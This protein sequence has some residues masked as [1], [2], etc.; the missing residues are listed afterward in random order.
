MKLL[1]FFLLLSIRLL[2]QT[3]SLHFL[4][5]TNVLYRGCMNILCLQHENIDF[6]L[7]RVV[8]DSCEWKK[9]SLHPEKIGLVPICLF[10]AKIKTCNFASGFATHSFS[11]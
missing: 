7:L 4:P 2:A 9:N 5:E 6:S 1:P 3:D 8:C 10:I 11:C